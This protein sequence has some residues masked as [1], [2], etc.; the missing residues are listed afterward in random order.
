MIGGRGGCGRGS[1]AGADR[2]GVVGPVVRRDAD[3]GAAVRSLDHVA[4]ADV[5]PDMVQVAAEEHQVPRLELGLGDVPAFVP[6]GAGVVVEVDPGLR[7][8]VLG[9]AAA[10]ERVRTGSAPD[11]RLAK[12]AVGPLDRGAGATGT[13]DDRSRGSLAEQLADRGPGCGL[14]GGERG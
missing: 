10:V 3:V 6:L 1:A 12:L 2:A 11:V 8:D 13:A 14:A 9:E 7:P 5:D 4:V